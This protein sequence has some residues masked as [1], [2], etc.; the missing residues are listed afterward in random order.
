MTPED[1]PRTL[2]DEVRRLRAGIVRQPPTTRDPRES[3]MVRVVSAAS[4]A[5]D[6]QL[7]RVDRFSRPLLPSATLN[8]ERAN[9]AMT[10][11]LFLEQVASDY[12]R[13]ASCSLDLREVEARRNTM[14]GNRILEYAGV[15]SRP[16]APLAVGQH[17]AADE[18]AADLASVVAPWL[19]STAEV[20]SQCAAA[21]GD[22]LGPLV[23]A[24]LNNSSTDT[25]IGLPSWSRRVGEMWCQEFLAAGAEIL[26]CPALLSR[27]HIDGRGLSRQES[28]DITETTNAVVALAETFRRVADVRVSATG[29]L[30]KIGLV[31]AG[32]AL[33]QD[34]LDRFAIS[35]QNIP[36]EV[37]ILPSQ[38]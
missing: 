8:D 7:D 25:S 6:G 32:D 5:W 24:A 1:N 28:A 23:Q 13:V 22:V 29:H 30:P 31:L 15:A 3:E 26:N 34:E 20:D 9:P 35:A 17:L 11:Q 4:L 16:V 27:S 36:A 33:S 21:F 10:S 37:T 19:I 2:E 18:H 14:Q 38:V 12:R